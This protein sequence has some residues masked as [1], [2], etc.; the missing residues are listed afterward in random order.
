MQH[1]SFG[2]KVVK[3]EIWSVTFFSVREEIGGVK[4]LVL[5]LEAFGSA[6]PT[7]RA[8][9]TNGR[10]EQMRDCLQIR[11]NNVIQL[12]M[13]WGKDYFDQ[14]EKKAVLK[15]KLICLEP[16]WV[17][18]EVKWDF[19]HVLCVHGGLFGCDWRHVQATSKLPRR[20]QRSVGT[21]VSCFP[22]R[23]SDVT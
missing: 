9:V 20:Y 11:R 3:N 21:C 1:C 22:G 6:T 18:W 19:S 2:G 15:W 17:A 8:T 5:N 12:I 14:T 10:L 7:Y 13:I 16:R 23:V 4:S